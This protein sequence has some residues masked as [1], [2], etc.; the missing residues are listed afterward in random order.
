MNDPAHALAHPIAS[1]DLA[2]IVLYLVG[3]TTAGLW[4]VRKLKMTGDAYF[5]AGRSLKWPVVGAALFAAN[6]S[7]IHLVGLA[8]SGYK[9]GLVWGNFE[10]MAVFTLILLGLVF[11]PFYF[12]TRIATL[13]EYLERRYNSTARAILAVMAIAAALL[14]HIGMSMYAGAAVFREFFGFDVRTSIVIIALIT[15]VYTV[16]GG[17]RAV[18]ITETI[19]AVLLIGSAVTVT[20]F[21]IHALPA[22]GIHSVAEFRA[23]LKPDQ[24]HMLLPAGRPDGL[25]WLPFLLGLPVLGIWYWCTDQTIVQRVLGAGSEEDAQR[26]A[27]F[28]GLLKILPVFILVFPGVCGYVLFRRQI[29]GDANQTYP[30]LLNSLL[31]TGVK[32]L[33]AAGLLASLMSAIAAASNSCATL[34]AVDIIKRLKPGASDRAQVLFGRISAVAVIL[35]AMAWSTQGGKY[36]SIFEAINAIA[37][38]IAPPITTCFL[39]GVFWKRGTPQAAVVT[40]VAGLLMG[41]AGFL[42]DL[43]AVGHVKVLTTTCGIPFLMQAWW[44]FVICSLIFCLTSW[45][46]PPPSP[47]KIRGLT[48]DAPWQVIFHG[49]L[50][51]IG[52]P[53]VLGGLLTGVMIVLYVLFR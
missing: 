26:G 35:L 52:D 13:P 38:F 50:T 23:A 14:I 21:A 22:A 12:R 2:I 48:W 43:P 20:L 46:T 31:P 28:A 11:A 25:G 19:Q 49:R 37:A 41:A 16:L 17:L 15:A 47:E 6:I 30:V 18:M 42:L 4:S 44:G 45:L 8:A 9:E 53:R 27:L 7:S 34:V 24:L 32:G 10:W 29:G 51:G 39:W 33:V 36:T 1:L 3:I 40:L 5:L